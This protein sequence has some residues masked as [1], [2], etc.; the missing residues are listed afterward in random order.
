[1]RKKTKKSFLVAIGVALCLAFGGTAFAIDNDSLESRTTEGLYDRTDPYDLAMEPGLLYKLDR[2]R[3]YTNLSGYEEGDSFLIGTSGKL[4]A[5]SLA[6]FYETNKYEYDWTNNDTSYNGRDNWTAPTA[7]SPSYDGTYDYLWA[8]ADWDKNENTTEE[9]NFYAAYS[10]DFGG[11]SVGLSYAPE[12]EEYERS[13]DFWGS[14]PDS[15]DPVVNLWNSQGF[16][17]FSVSPG[18]SYGDSYGSISYNPADHAQYSAYAESE[19]FSGKQKADRTEHPFKLQSQIHINDHWHLLVGVGYASIE[20]EDDFS[21]AYSYSEVYEDTTGQLE[22]YDASISV[23][24]SLGEDYEGD[25]W[26]IY[27]EPVYEVND[28]VSLRMDLHY[29]REDGDS[30]GGRVGTGNA[31]ETDRLTTAA[32]TETWTW[33]ETWN[34]SSKGDSEEDSWE[35]EPRVYLTFDKVR[36]S[37]GAGYHYSKEKWDGTERAD[38]SVRYTYNDGDGVANDADDWTFVGSW[39]GSA[40][41]DGTEKTRSWRFPV[42]TEFDIT[43][44]L[45]LRA[46]AA[47]YRT[48]ITLKENWSESERINE[49]YTQTNGIGTVIAVGPEAYYATAAAVPEAYDADAHGSTDTYKL[50]QTFDSTTYHLGLGYTFT[51]NLK[52]DL[53]WTGSDG[54][55]DTDMLYASVTLTF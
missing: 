15:N 30:K 51:E 35:I 27:L 50:D 55:V 25:E 11:V 46:G 28:M 7:V 14:F 38:K 21:G 4:G 33:S 10:I 22:T 45:T 3:L 24:G 48:R 18:S 44:K 40:N 32:D 2:W 49:N 1:M 53:M 47:Y 34:S 17:G 43:D 6:F 19:S 16:W 23:N 26:G 42:A 31:T 41:Y 52:C 20:E 13:L 54:A 9:N 37:L 12:F 5:G 8:N 39:T 29:D 36:F